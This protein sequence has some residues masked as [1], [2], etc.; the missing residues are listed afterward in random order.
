MIKTAVAIK[1]RNLDE[2]KE[3]I[4]TFIHHLLRKITIFRFDKKS[5]VTGVIAMLL[6][7][8]RSMVFSIKCLP[9]YLS[10]IIDIPF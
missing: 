10:K 8:L 9:I 6:A 5:D 7:L 1:S 3:L 4:D 2:L